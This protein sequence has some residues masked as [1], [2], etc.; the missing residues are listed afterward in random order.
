MSRTRA[1]TKEEA[2]IVKEAGL[3]AMY[4]QGRRPVYSLNQ[5]NDALDR[6]EAVA[7]ATQI[8]SDA[9][10][11]TS[12]EFRQEV[13]EELM[14]GGDSLERA[15]NRTRDQARLFAEARELGLM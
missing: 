13:I 15:T 5:I 3:K 1:L 9:E 7:V 12:A 14:A 6:K 11:F 8:K 10:Y 4:H 2:N